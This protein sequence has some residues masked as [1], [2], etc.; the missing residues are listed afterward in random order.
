MDQDA[1]PD[2]SPV[3][4]CNGCE[5]MDGRRRFLQHASVTLAGIALSLIGRPAHAGEWV[6]RHAGAIAS[7]GSTATY[8]VPDVDGATIDAEREVVVVRWKG[9]AYAFSLVCPHKRALLKWRERE[10][11]FNCPKHKSK[12]HP[13]GAFI[14]GKAT[15]GMDRHGLRKQGGSLIVDLGAVYKQDV[16]AAQW[17]AAVVRV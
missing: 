3:S 10:S 14:S 13:D 9:A 12:Y 2:A 1:V 5:L 4:S 15:R 8:R 17:A 11:T 7:D 6:V 16:H